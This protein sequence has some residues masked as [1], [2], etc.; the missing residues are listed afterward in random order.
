[1]TANPILKG[2]VGEHAMCVY[3]SRNG[4]RLFADLSLRERG[5]GGCDVLAAGLVLQVKTMSPRNYRQ[6]L[7]RRV[8][9]QKRLRGLECDAF[10]LAHWPGK[11]DVHLL[12]WI[13]AGR[14][15]EVGRLRLSPINGAG[16][17]NL[18]IPDKALFPLPD[19]RTEIDLRH[20]A[21][22]A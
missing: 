8:D 17:W 21:A 12:G 16:H 7:I 5:D 20:E 11:L 3:L 22:T 19:L 14:A 13:W 10:V 1:M 9:S 4:L 15:S 18:V 6:L 2:M